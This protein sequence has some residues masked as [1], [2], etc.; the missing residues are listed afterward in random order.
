MK[1]TRN[2]DAVDQ[3]VD[4]VV[5]G[6][7]ETVGSLRRQL[8]QPNLPNMTKVKVAYALGELR[9]REGT[10]VLM[11]NIN[12]VA[13]RGDLAIDIARWGQY[14]AREAL[15][16]IGRY[17]SRTIMDIIG[18]QKFA[19][20]SVDGYAAVLAEIEGA[21]YAVMK[22]KDRMRKAKDA[23]VKQRYQMVIDGVEAIRELQRGGK[24]TK[25]TGADQGEE[26]G[27]RALAEGGLPPIV[28]LLI[29]VAIGACA[30]TLI[31]LAKKKAA[32]P[33]K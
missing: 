16:K 3:M 17:A 6:Y 18:S 5:K 7:N 11:E 21:S 27:A 4:G 20:P 9:A 13:E 24:Q 26:P 15:V 2:E 14:P 31:M 30:A 23:T 12:L 22:L 10:W 25:Q 19:Q 28:F 29:G 8:K 33:T 1:E 32:G